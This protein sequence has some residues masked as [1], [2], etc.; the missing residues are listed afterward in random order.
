MGG[1]NGKVCESKEIEISRY[2]PEDD[3]WLEWSTVKDLITL[4]YS[5]DHPEL[6]LG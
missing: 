1:I 3:T 5:K 2:E 4:E 6:N